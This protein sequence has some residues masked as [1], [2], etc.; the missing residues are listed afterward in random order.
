M[1]G[2]V[3]L[4]SFEKGISVQENKSRVTAMCDA[5]AHRGPDSA[6]VWQDEEKGLALGHR[7]LAILDLSPEGHQPMLSASGRYVVSY[8]GEIYN[9]QDLEAD[10]RAQGHMFR[11]RSDTEILLSA[12]DQYGLNQTCQKINGMFAFILWDRK[13]KVLHLVRDRFGKKPLYFGWAGKNL[14]MASEL[15][16]LTA[17]PDFE[18]EINRE[19]LTLYMRY[20][21]VPAPFSIYKNVWHLM[22]GGRLSLPVSAF[23]PGDDINA[24]TQ[25]YWHMPSVIRDAKDRFV[26]DKDETEYIDEFEH[27]LTQCVGDRMMS[28][29]PLGAFL[30][31]GIDSSTIVALMQKQSSQPV[32]TYAIGFNEKGFD[33]AQ[34]AADI[35]AHLGT[36]HHELYVSAQEALNVI[37]DLPVYYDEP[38]SDPSQ[39]PTYLVSKFARQDVTVALS[40]DGGDEM[41]GG[42]N[43]HVVVP[44]VWQKARM[45]PWP[46]RKTLS[47]LM[48]SVSVAH[49]DRIR[50]A[51]PQFGERMHKLAGLLPQRNTKEVYRHLVSQ[52]QRPE[53]IVIQGKE[54]RHPANDP[55]WDL[56]GLS[57]AET[58]MY[59][60]ALSYLNGDILTKL[61]RATM[62]VSLEGRS[63]FLDKRV[64]EYVWALPEHMKIRGKHGKWLLRQVLARHVPTDMF[65]RPKQGFTPPIA[66]W[67]RGPLKEWADALLDQKAIET[68]GFF[69]AL[70]IRRCWEAHCA[71]KGDHALRLWTVLMFQAWYKK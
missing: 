58:M 33:E 39:I 28:D 38:F 27:I 20:G 4:F 15:K 40:G 16:A 64:F 44:P 3:G 62:A 71:G 63:P 43:R 70:P 9:Y 37:P 5:L 36:E 34:Q 19:S 56:E 26:I 51:Q 46:A 61:D 24:K 57:F 52:W 8:N 32:K 14:V 6:G 23:K 68:D 49:W 18:T 17:H 2:I 42:Y 11:G 1:C 31:G 30:S 60:D 13:E 10:L 67:L 35:A 21:Y 66:A 41:L 55:A 29:V 48:Q 25:L 59:K 47:V 50:S 54:P 22:P 12:I 7:R 65:E 45:L 53:D 69:K